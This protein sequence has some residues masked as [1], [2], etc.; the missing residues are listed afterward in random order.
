MTGPLIILAVGGLTVGLYFQ[1]T[2]D[3]LDR[4]GFLMQTPALTAL[5]TGS[6][7][8]RGARPVATSP[9]P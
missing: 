3:F 8:A 2:G 9:W 4:D 7:R 5:Q 1:C 6:R